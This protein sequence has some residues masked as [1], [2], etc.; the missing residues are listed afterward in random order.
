MHDVGEGLRGYQLG[1]WRGAE[2]YAAWDSSCHWYSSR[3]SPNGKQLAVLPDF[4][5]PWLLPLPPSFSASGSSQASLTNLS[6]SSKRL[7]SRAGTVLE[8]PKQL[9]TIADKAPEGSRLG[10]PQT[11]ISCLINPFYASLAS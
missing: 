9:D 11:P 8:P 3:L 4:P 7:D 5:S 2:A 1:P 6:K 10:A